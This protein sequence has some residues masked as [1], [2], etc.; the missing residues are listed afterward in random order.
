M[1]LAPSTIAGG[2]GVGLMA[3]KAIASGVDSFA[4][5]NPEMLLKARDVFIPLQKA[6]LA[7]HLDL[8]TGIYLS[9]RNTIHTTAE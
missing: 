5:P 8:S 9:I 3:L 6:E 7:R 4:A 2:A 1:K